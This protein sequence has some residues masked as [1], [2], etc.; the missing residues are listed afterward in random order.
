MF[1][2]AQHA[3]QIVNWDRMHQFCGRCGA[4]TDYSQSER[5]KICPACEAHYYPRVSP[6]VIV[7]I[8]RENKLLLMRNKRYKHNF[9]SVLAGFVEPGESLEAAIV[10]EVKEEVGIE[11]KNIRYFA[12]QPWPFPDSLMIGFTADYAGGNLVPDGFEI[13][14][15]GWYA[16]DD[17]PLIPG[18]ISIARKLIDAFVEEQKKGVKG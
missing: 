3:F 5:V 11:V 18:P 15:A 13:S 4:E 17:L 9:Y 16:V 1:S 14:E 12:S 7:A 10:R 8:H 2:I 6:A